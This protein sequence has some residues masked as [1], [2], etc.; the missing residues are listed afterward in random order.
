M[1]IPGP[2]PEPELGPE[3]ELGSES[4]PGPGLLLQCASD[5]FLTVLFDQC[6]ISVFFKCILS[7]LPGFRADFSPIIRI[8][9]ILSVLS[10]F[11]GDYRLL[12]AIIGF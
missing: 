5:L 10:A 1:C 2:G 9:G 4:V 3:L 11:N 7:G 6:I 12:T 8:T